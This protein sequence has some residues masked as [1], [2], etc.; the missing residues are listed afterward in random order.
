MKTMM[1][2]QAL[3]QLY[4]YIPPHTRMGSVDLQADD[5]EDDDQT[6]VEDVCNAQGKAQENAYYST[7]ESE[8]RD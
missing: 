4:K 1:N 3:F 6:E 2:A 5:T 8:S 7:P